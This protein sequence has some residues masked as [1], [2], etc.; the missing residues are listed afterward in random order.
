MIE[1]HYISMSEDDF[2][3]VIQ[4]LG[5]SIFEDEGR[6]FNKEHKD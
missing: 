4:E 2:T 1:V 3:V 5:K 6:Y